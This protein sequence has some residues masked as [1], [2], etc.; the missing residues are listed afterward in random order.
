MNVA[1]APFSYML[2]KKQVLHRLSGFRMRDEKHI[3]K[4]DIKK[5]KKGLWNKVPMFCLPIRARKMRYNQNS[6]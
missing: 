2:E 5:E 3:Y 1:K 4:K 6:D